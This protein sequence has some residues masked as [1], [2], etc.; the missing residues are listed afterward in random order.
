MKASRAFVLLLV[1]VCL[2]TGMSAGQDVQK[3]L[4]SDEGELIINFSSEFAGI[5]ES[6]DVIKFNSPDG[7]PGIFQISKNPELH[8][9]NMTEA[10]LSQA[11]KIAHQDQVPL[12]D[13]M[14]DGKLIPVAELVKRQGL[15]YATMIRLSESDTIL[16]V[17]T[18]GKVFDSLMK[19]TTYRKVGLEEDTFT[20]SS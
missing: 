12:R 1:L 5:E 8:N 13:G 6:T 9:Q 14:F 3:H 7:V 4:V 20:S 19:N 10:L 17:M 11:A 16:T 15:V 2:A 18:S